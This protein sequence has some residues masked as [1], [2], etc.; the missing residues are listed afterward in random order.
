MTGLRRSLFLLAFLGLAMAPAQAHDSRPL[1]IEIVESEAGQVDLTWKT[2]AS[3]AFPNRPLVTLDDGCS[4]SLPPRV[5]AANL[6]GRVTYQC[7][8]GVSGRVLGI[9]YP[10]YNPSLST[11]MRVTYATGEVQ[12][13]RAGPDEVAIE[14]PSAETA[15]GVAIQYGILGV[16]HILLGFDH[17]LFL[18][19]LVLIA[20]TLRRIVITVTGFTLA[21]SLTL[22]LASLDLV[23]V[24]IPPV[25]AVIALSIVFLATELARE[26]RDTL[27]WRYP[28]SVSASFGLLHGFGFASVLADIGLPQRE[29]PVALL[30]FNLGVEVGQLLFIAVLLPVLWLLRKAVGSDRLTRPIAYL[31]GALASYW[32][33]DRIAG[34]TVA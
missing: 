2:P 17:L 11:L 31:V 29:V 1:Y 15:G 24:P 5:D 23:R 16:E 27:T 25:E 22:A 19:C 3:V 30:S 28:I 13:V 20:G 34:F 8:E 12:T 7:T 6:I 4:S 9:E 18:A 32:M 33:I 21:H 14:L 10:G 26:R